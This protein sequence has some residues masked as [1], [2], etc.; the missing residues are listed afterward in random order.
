[1]FSGVALSASSVPDDLVEQYGL[2]RRAYERGGEKEF[3]FLLRDFE[4]VLPVW[5]EGRLQIAHWGTRRGQSKRLPC[6][7]RTSSSSWRTCG[8]SCAGS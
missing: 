5:L 1:M 2:V 6:T 7:A 3:Q 4:R 8:G